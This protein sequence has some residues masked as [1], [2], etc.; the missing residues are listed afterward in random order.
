MQNNI[1]VG[2]HIHHLMY[3]KTQVNHACLLITSEMVTVLEIITCINMYYSYRYLC[4][5]LVC[6]WSF[7]QPSPLY[8]G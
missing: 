7:P 5:F 4:L 3:Y 2:A 8:N 1:A 6:G